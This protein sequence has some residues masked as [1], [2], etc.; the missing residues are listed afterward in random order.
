M[1]EP[2]PDDFAAIPVLAQL[3][4][5]NPLTLLGLHGASQCDGFPLLVDLHASLPR[6][7]TSLGQ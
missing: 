1:L 3:L 2:S 4:K 6:F 7:D 5:R